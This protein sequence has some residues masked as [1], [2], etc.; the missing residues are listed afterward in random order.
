MN[1]KL[2]ADRKPS[3]RRVHLAQQII[4]Y[5]L[6]ESWP[7]G[8]HVVEQYLVDRLSVSRSPVRAALKLLQE[9]GLLEAKA[10][11]GFYLAVEG[12]KLSEFALE[13]PQTAEEQL[14]ITLIEGRAKGEQNER[15]TQTEIMRQYEVNR[16]TATNTLKR[17]QDEG[18]IVRNA[19]QGWSFVPTLDSVQSRQSSY[20]FRLALEPASILSST[21]KVDYQLLTGQRHEHLDL[22][23]AVTQRQSNVHW[24]Y[25]VDAN[26]HEAIAMMSGNQF[27]LNAVSQQNRLRTILELWDGS[28]LERVEEWCHEHLKIIEALERGQLGQAS[29]F[30]AEHLTIAAQGAGANTD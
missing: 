29:K 22:L 19:G 2:G 23:N 15:F 3:K 28:N 6:Q 24:I 16:T 30:M 14:Y 18:L 13:T 9:Q 12:R 20:E 21:F 4:Q 11:H 8:H 10:N 1:E 26:F 5:A 27:F 17:M 25:K 7:K